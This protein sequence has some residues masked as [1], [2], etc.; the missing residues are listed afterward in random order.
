MNPLRVL[1][2][3]PFAAFGGATKSLAEMFAALPASSVRGT[4]I[5]PPGVAAD[6]LR[7]AGLDVIPAR[8]V[9]QWDDTRFGHYRGARW[10]ILVRELALWP[11]TFL[12]LRKAARAGVYDL[13]HSNE[14]TALLPGLLARRMLSA[15]LLVHVRSLQRGGKG[16]R[17]SA[18]LQRLLRTRADAVVAIDD[19]V[20]RTLPASLAVHVI[21]NGMKV[22]AALPSRESVG[23][24][25]V[26]IVGVLHRSKGVY[27]LLEATRLL[28]DRGVEV[29]VLVVG[30]N[31]HRLVGV[32]G[33]LLRK[34]DF[35]RDV[36][37]DLEAYVALHGLNETVEFTGFVPDIRPIYGRVD[38]V[39]FPSLLDAPGRPVF[40]AALFGLPTIVAMRDPTR[41]VIVHGETGLCIDRPTPVAIADAIQALAQDRALARRM[42]EQARR[43]ALERFESRVCAAKMLALYRETCAA[44]GAAQ[45]ISRASTGTNAAV[46]PTPP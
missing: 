10:L 33:W 13:V 3:H 21:H 27:E 8:G 12:A 15:P 23:G 17:I 14:I 26:G 2:L 36:R 7:T 11:A 34:L 41:D 32:R 40:E 29:K 19:A 39:C 42:G 28:R 44:K 31:V 16:G 1:Y 30:E 4:V 35:A 46:P 5:C 37:G 25:C 24:L 6:S 20:R 9:A 45:P 18:W 43:M 38:V 22:P